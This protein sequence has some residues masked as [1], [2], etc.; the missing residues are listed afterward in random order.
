[1]S[2]TVFA[3]MSFVAKTPRPVNVQLDRLVEC[4]N[5]HQCS[6]FRS[7]NPDFHVWTALERYARLFYID[8]HV[9]V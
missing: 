7:I 2:S 4:R 8:T 6:T 5:G 9:C 1:M 3:G